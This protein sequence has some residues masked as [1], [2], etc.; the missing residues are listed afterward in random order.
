MSLGMT[1]RA[2]IASSPGMTS[3]AKL[4]GPLIRVV[5]MVV[6]PSLSV[7]MD[8]KGAGASNATMT[9]LKTSKEAR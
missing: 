9:L 7:D 4:D 3:D 8:V 6:Q 5:V 2:R 1:V